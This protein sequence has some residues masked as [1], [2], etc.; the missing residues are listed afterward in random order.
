MS[1]PVASLFVALRASSRR[2][3]V[4]RRKQLLKLCAEDK[5]LF[6]VAANAFLFLIG[7]YMV[8]WLYNIVSEAEAGEPAELKISAN[9]QANAQTT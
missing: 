2:V 9:N 7:Q 8:S 6:A 1:A 4:L 3:V 5:L